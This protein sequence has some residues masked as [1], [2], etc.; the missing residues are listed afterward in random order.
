MPGGGRL[1]GGCR[2]SDANVELL[3]RAWAAYDR[4]DVE[5]FAACL[6]DDWREFSP[7][8]D[9]GSLED[10]RR[11]MEAHRVAFPDKHTEIHQIVA[12]AEFVACHCTVTATQTGP[13]L[14]LPA[15]GKRVVLHEMMFNRVSDGR[16][17]ETWAMID[18]P[19]FY[20]QLAGRPAPEQLDNMG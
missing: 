16:L 10:E 14:D 17:A 6:A 13:Y 1:A 19:G 11:T 12:D 4:G 8:G 2:L 15:T 18:G 7:A 5:A 20:E 3:R 9:S